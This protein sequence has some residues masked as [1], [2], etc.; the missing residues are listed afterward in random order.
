MQPAT[1]PTGK[2]EFR[3][4]EAGDA[5]LLFRIYAS[6]RDWELAG[7]LWAPADRE[8]FLRGQFRLQSQ[9]YATAFPGAVHRIIQ[10]DATDIGR[11]IVNRPDDHMRI[12]DLAIL[13]QWRGRGIGSGILRALMAEAQG[14]KVPVRLHVE[15]ENPALRLY[16]RLGF[17]QIAAR[18]H[19]F[20]LEWRPDLRPRQI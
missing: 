4:I 2:I 15:R 10:L 5:A 13:P 19:H 11:L 20:E 9:G 18:G 14:G 6:T 1:Q 16:H 17:R 12:V 3:V 7:A 8:D